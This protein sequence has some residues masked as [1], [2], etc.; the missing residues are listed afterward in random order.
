MKR[1]AGVF[2]TIASAKTI[3]LAGLVILSASASAEDRMSFREFR[4]QN[5]GIDRS[6]ARQM[7]HAQ[8]GRGGG[9]ANATGV[10]LVNP[11]QHVITVGPDGQAVCGGGIIDGGR[12]NHENRVRNQSFQ[13]LTSGAITR[14]NKGV[15][16]DLG[17]ANKNIV[18][19]RN[20]FGANETV[21]VS[22]GG[23]TETFSAGSQVTAA[24]YVAVKQVLSGGGQQVKV[25]RSGRAEGGS[26]DL[27]SLTANNDVMRA[28]SLVVPKDVTTYG[29]FG[30]GSD[31]RLSGD[32]SNFGTVQTLSSDAN[33]RG[34]GIHADNIT[35]N[36]GA[37]INAT[38]DLSLNAAKNLSNFGTISASGNLALSAGGAV[39]N[40]GTVSSNGDLTVTSATVANRGTLASTNGNVNF[41][42]A[43]GDLVVDNRRGTVSAANAINVR[44]AAY[45][46]T[47]NALV[48]GGD[49]LSRELNLNSGL[50]TVNVNVGELSGTVNETGSA[51]HVWADTSNLNIGSVCLT[52]D[53][54]FFNSAGAINIVGNILVSEDLTII[55]SGDIR[56]NEG[57]SIQAGDATRGYNITLISGADFTTSGGTNQGSLGPITGSPPYSGA[58]SVTLSGKA[59]KTGGRVI[60]GSLSDDPLTVLT[61]VS[62]RPTDTSG[63]KNSGNI[64]IFAF[65]KDN[66]F[67]GAQNASLLASGAGT[68]NNG[69]VLIVAE[70]GVKGNANPTIALGEIKTNG[71]GANGNVTVVT[72]APVVT[73]VEPKGKIKTVTYLANG[74]RSPE[75]FL[76]P[77][78]KYIKTGGIVTSSTGRVIEA[79]GAA[80]F[81]S[82]GVSQPGDIQATSVIVYGGLGIL[83]TTGV[84]KGSFAVN[85]VTGSKGDIGF[86]SAPVIVEALSPTTVVGIVTNNGRASVR[87]T[88]ASTNLLAEDSQDLVIVARTIDEMDPNNEV[89]T[90]LTGSIKAGS[91]VF[92]LNSKDV[93]NLSI[94]AGEFIGLSTTAN[95]SDNGTRLVAPRVA[96]AVDGANVGTSTLSPM[97]LSNKVEEFAVSADNVYVNVAAGS[98]SIDLAGGAANGNFF[99]DAATSVNVTG[100]VRASDIRLGTTAGEFV[101]HNGNDISGGTNV[102][103]QNTGVGKKDKITIGNSVVLET[104]GGNIAVLLGGLTGTVAPDPANVTKSG[105]VSIRGTGLTAKPPVNTLSAGAGAINISNTIGVK[106]LNLLGNVIMINQAF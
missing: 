12:R 5:E 39:K 56:A 23:K 22:I 40:A 67:V 106:N 38:G 71:A 61:T 28:S 101:I 9:G 11:V 85:L 76:G 34:G 64:E 18:L 97:I 10:S 73:N 68:G 21:Q 48:L 82:G 43:S 79:K 45:T 99:F 47:G 44:D 1:F 57:V 7:F 51:A 2:S 50:G 88:G 24:E 53:P 104:V 102:R 29:D 74:S 58:G 42:T 3:A 35:N 77:E 91:T 17:S 52:G 94:S 8:Y 90:D 72:S 36:A 98:K 33:V 70:G 55:A 105:N 83:P 31:F 100:N 87:L 65:G 14:V 6:A 75:T 80:S 93:S 60:L 92:V 30:R 16:L 78:Q 41:A 69:N 59:S 86:P 49:L 84:L 25:D 20:L 15:E 26:V 19:G 95:F 46:G 27:G 66:G 32:L 54:T 96:L 89:D 81:F 4:Q 13:E 62:S 63:N 103:I 37:L